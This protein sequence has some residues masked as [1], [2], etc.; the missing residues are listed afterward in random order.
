MTPPAPQPPPADPELPESSGSPDG[1]P[2]QPLPEPPPPGQ[3]YRMAWMLYLLLALGGVVWIGLREGSI[4]VALF[5]DLQTWW[6]DLGLGV[7]AGLGLLVLWETTRRL[8]PLARE[9]ES[10]LAR[11]LGY[12]EPEEAIALAALSGFAEE[13]FFRG[14]VQGAFDNYGWFWAAAFFALLHTGP[15]AAFRLWT[16]FAF[17]AGLLFGILMAWRGN[18]LAPVVAHTLVNGVNLLRITRR[19]NSQDEPEAV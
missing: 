4:P 11:V 9:L 8:V 7:A 19:A 18:L 12:L 13:W 2:G 10:H 16:L 1:G 15:G 5:I 14:A 3:L 17:V 6:V